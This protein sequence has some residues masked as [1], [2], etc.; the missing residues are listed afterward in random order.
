MHAVLAVAFAHERYLTTSPGVPSFRSVSELSHFSQSIALL[1]REI[2]KPIESRDRDALWATASLHSILLFLA[3]DGRGPDEAW[4]LGDSSSPSDSGSLDWLR[5]IDA[6]WVLWDLTNPTRQ[7]GLFRCLSHLY[8]GLRRDSTPINGIHGVHASLA[9]LCELDETS[10]TETSPYF[11]AAHAICRL[12]TRRNSQTATDSDLIGVVEFISGMDTS[13]KGLIT[14]R[15][16]RALFL[17]FLWYG[18][19]ARAVWWVQLRATME[20][21]AICRYLTRYHGQNSWVQR[22]FPSEL[23]NPDSWNV[24]T[25]L[26]SDLGPSTVYST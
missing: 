1:G 16:P 9:D 4:P 25:S 22:F 13:F 15:D 18:E 26:Q 2:A 23:G 14:R 17:L 12:E 19:A 6:K 11:A 24:F 7:D 5:M 21:V 20:R 10:S 8:D 3:M